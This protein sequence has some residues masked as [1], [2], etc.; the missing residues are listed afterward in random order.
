MTVKKMYYFV[1]LANGTEHTISEEQ[2]NNL[3]EE[4]ESLGWDYDEFSRDFLWSAINDTHYVQYENCIRFYLNENT[5]TI[6]YCQ[7]EIHQDP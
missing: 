5:K 3:R 1:E 6:G 2:Y 7:R 4:Y